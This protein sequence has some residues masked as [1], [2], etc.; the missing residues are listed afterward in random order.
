MVCV[1]LNQVLGK[2]NSVAEHYFFRVDCYLSE[3]GYLQVRKTLLNPASL[4][5]NYMGFRY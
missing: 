2:K 5:S 3:N 4:D 1:V